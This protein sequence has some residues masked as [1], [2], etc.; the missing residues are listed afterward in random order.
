MPTTAGHATP[1]QTFQQSN[2]RVKNIIQEA[3]ALA[4]KAKST[5]ETLSPT[6]HDSSRYVAVQMFCT[7][8]VQ[9]LQSPL[10]LEKFQEA[11]LEKYKQRLNDFKNEF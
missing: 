3:N 11:D 10:H 2:V 7:R 8:L 1:R 6:S 4:E 5:L 9:E